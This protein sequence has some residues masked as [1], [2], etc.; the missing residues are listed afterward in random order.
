MKTYN[1]EVVE[2]LSTLRSHADLPV[3]LA[4]QVD[5]VI[6]DADS[7]LSVLWSGI[8]SYAFVSVLQT[9]LLDGLSNSAGQRYMAQLAGH[10]PCEGVRP[11]TEGKWRMLIDAYWRISDPDHDTLGIDGNWTQLQTNELS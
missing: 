11:L 1:H 5:D 9:I 2:I 7:P 6:R 10:L 8:S 3:H 4:Q